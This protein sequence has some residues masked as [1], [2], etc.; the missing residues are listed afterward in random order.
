MKRN[1]ES[2]IHISVLTLRTAD[3]VAD[4]FTKPMRDAN[5]FHKLRRI[6]M[7]ESEP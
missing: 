3:N 6:I 4:L 7:N 1:T 5:A 2:L